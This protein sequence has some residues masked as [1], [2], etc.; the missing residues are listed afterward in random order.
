MTTD[1]KV[2]E[3]GESVNEATVHF[4]RDLARFELAR[5]DPIA[6]ALIA[7]AQADLGNGDCGV[8]TGG[9]RKT[10]P[11]NSTPQVA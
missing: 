1:I 3:M 4:G 6:H 7:H 11:R 5:G 9:H 8:D 2:P 10:R